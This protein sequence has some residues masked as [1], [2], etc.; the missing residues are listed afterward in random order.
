MKIISVVGY[1]NS[2]KTTLIEYLICALKNKGYRVGTIKKIH[3]QGYEIDK[4]GKDTYRHKVAGADIVT[5]Y[6]PNSTDIMF[7]SQIDLRTVIKIY[8]VDYLLLEGPFEI[9][10]PRIVTASTVDGIEPFLND[11]VI[12]ISGIVSE[13]MENYPNY[14]ILNS[15]RDIEQMVKLIENV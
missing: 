15:S 9:V 6:S 5:G 12:F 2:G 3:C 8:D 4:K 14:K 7:Q 10:A 1:S 11:E 13:S